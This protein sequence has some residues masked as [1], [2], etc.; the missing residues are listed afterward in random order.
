MDYQIPFSQLCFLSTELILYVI[1]ILIILRQLFTE[2]L[3]RL[4]SSRIWSKFHEN[5]GNDSYLNFRSSFLQKPVNSA[6]KS[7]LLFFCKVIFL[8]I[9]LSMY[10]IQVVFVRVS[11]GK[12]CPFSWWLLFFWAHHLRVSWPALLSYSVPPLTIQLVKVAH[13]LLT[14]LCF[15]STVVLFSEP[16]CSVELNTLH[17]NT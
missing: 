5:E 2:F 13:P 11:S 15:L 4:S 14:S 17:C 12:N 9:C 10:A 3:C 6:C 16:S 7:L 1:L 8:K